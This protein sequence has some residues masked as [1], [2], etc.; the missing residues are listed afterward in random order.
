MGVYGA[1]AQLQATLNGSELVDIDNGGAVKVRTT[2]GAIAALAARDDGDSNTNVGA[3]VGT[4]L[5]A[6]ALVSGL[7]NR[8]GPTAAF[9]DTTDTAANIAAASVVGGSFY[10]TIK[11]ATAFVQTLA[12]GTGVTLPATVIVPPNSAATYLVS[13]VSAAAV[14]FVPVQISPL[15]LPTPEVVTALNTVG[16]GTITGAAIAGGVVSR[17]GSQANAAFTDTTDTAANIIAGQPNARVGQSWEVTYQNTTNATATIGGGTGVTVSGITTVQAGGSARFLVTYTAANTITMQGISS[18]NPS[19]ANGTFTA[20]GATAVT[21]T[22][23]RITANS[24]VLIGLKTIGGTPAGA[25]FM[26]A[27]TAGTSFQVKSV[28]GDTSV[29]NY[30]IIG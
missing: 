17:G 22:D 4:T 1:G 6:A 10:F 11:N 8:F 9:T 30:M 7:I 13:V 19:S 16:A 21:V 27:V 23:S 26:S 25:P 2:T 29:Y 14:T 18:A 3:A 12:A 24:V 28:A 15:T 20:N 5:T